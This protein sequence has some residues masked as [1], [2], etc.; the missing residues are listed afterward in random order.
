MIDQVYCK[1]WN[2][3]PPSDTKNDSKNGAKKD[4]KKAAFV[5]SKTALEYFGRIIDTKMGLQKKC[6]S[7]KNGSTKSDYFIFDVG[8]AY[9]GLY[10]S[11]GCFALKSQ[12][13]S[14]RICNFPEFEFAL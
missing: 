1:N 3:R 2:K 12:N 6:D 11:F 10:S 5:G 9:F 13:L 4:S 14:S 8:G 7:K